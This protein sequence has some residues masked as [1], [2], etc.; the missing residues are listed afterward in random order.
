MAGISFQPNVNNIGYGTLDPSQ[1]KVLDRHLTAPPGSPVVGARYIVAA[2][3]TGAWAGK[4]KYIAEYSSGLSWDFTAPT[5]GMTCWIDD[6]N[7]LYFYDGSAWDLADK[8]FDHGSLKGLTD[9]DHT[10]Y[11]NDTRGDARYYQQSEFMAS[12]AGATDAGKPI[13]LDTAGKI[14]SSMI[15]SSVG[16]GVQVIE[17]AFGG[18]S[19]Y[20]DSTT[21][22]PENALVLWARIYYR[23]VGYNSHATA[24][25]VGYDGDTDFIFSD[26]ELDAIDE[27]DEY[28]YR[29]LDSYKKDYALPLTWS[30]SEKNLRVTITDSHFTAT[31][32]V[33]YVW[34]AYVE[35]K[36]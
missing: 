33:G 17:L 22:I 18:T 1:G 23:N 9:D 32:L 28:T 25:N 3:A 34:L 11:H 19:A 12:S 36:A 29:D 2:V 5:E 15:P 7:V 8:Q 4:E 13:K 21:E 16:G 10:Q 31:G 20:Y 26:A 14:D 35:K 27:T 6:E 30:A 24:V